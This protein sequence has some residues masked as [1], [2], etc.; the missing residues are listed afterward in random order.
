MEDKAT[1]YLLANGRKIMLYLLTDSLL[2]IEPFLR[3]V[4]I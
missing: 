4:C 2:V 3:T 1:G